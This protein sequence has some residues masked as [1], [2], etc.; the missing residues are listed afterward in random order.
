MMQKKPNIKHVG[1]W[2]NSHIHSN[3]LIYNLQEWEIEFIWILVVLESVTCH[4][5]NVFWRNNGGW[6]AWFC[7]GSAP[8]DC[9]HCRKEAG[10]KHSYFVQWNIDPC[11]SVSVHRGK[12][13]ARDQLREMQ[14]NK[15]FY[16][17]Q[18]EATV[19]SCR[20]NGVW[21]PLADTA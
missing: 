21:N 13:M 10:S 11:P 9:A 5:Y 3:D 2:C 14:E 20:P 12:E 17:N 16:I 8:G 19:G 4:L 7:T 18:W 15:L 6:R 1:K